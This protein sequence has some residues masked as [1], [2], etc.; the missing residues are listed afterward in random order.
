MS[1]ESLSI[2]LHHSKTTGTAKLV[3]IGIANHDG[4]GG[5]WPSI[6]TL[7]KYA[8]GIDRRAVQRA[9]VKLEELGEIRRV[10]QAGGDDETA[11]HRRPNRYRFLLACPPFCDRTSQHRDSRKP[12][13]VV[14]ETLSTGAVEGP[15]RG[16]STAGG[17]VEGPPEPSFNLT[18]NIEF[19][20]SRDRA[21]AKLCPNGHELVDGY[22]II[23]CRA[24][25]ER[26]VQELSSLEGVRS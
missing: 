1:I 7:A 26:R 14:D 11:D 5:S 17:A 21:R 20:N 24:D 18:T 9:I 2:A 25:Y 12:L 13:F 10:V 16:A 6:A 4:D 3:L 19:V 8:G 23:G 22:C 15:P